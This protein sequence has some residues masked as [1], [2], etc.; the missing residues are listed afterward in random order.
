MLRHQNLLLLLQNQ[1][2]RQCRLLLNLGHLRHRY[3]VRRRFFLDFPEAPSIHYP[4]CHSHQHLRRQ[5]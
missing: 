5:Q 3:Q 4:N 1:Q 2:S